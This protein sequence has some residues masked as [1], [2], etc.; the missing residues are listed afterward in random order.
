MTPDPPRHR[1]PT[2]AV[3]LL[4]LD[5]CG[6]SFG[7]RAAEPSPPRAFEKAILEAVSAD[8]AA[9]TVRDLVALGPR[10]GGTPSG[11]RA[12][13]YMRRR[14]QA[15]GL[16]VEELVD[17]PMD[18]HEEI[19]WEARLEEPEAPLH[20]WPVGFSPS[21]RSSRL[22]LLTAPPGP[23]GAGAWALLTGKDP[24]E[25][26]PQAV[27][28]G[29]VAILSDDD[30]EETLDP[31][32]AP[33]REFSGAGAGLLPAFCLSASSGRAVRALLEEGRP[34]MVRLGLV[35]RISR[36][37]PRT[38]EAT[39]PGKRRGWYLVVAHGD[40]DSGG[41]GAD[42]NASGVSSLLEVASALA[43]AS[44]SG[45][46]PVER[47]SIRFVVPGREIVSTRAY[48]AHRAGEIADLMGVFNFDQTGTS[49]GMD[50]L[51]FEGNDVPWNGPILRALLSVAS[52]YA[53]RFGF[54][55]AYTTNPTLGGTDACVFLPRAHHGLGF[56]PKEIPATTIFTAAWGRAQTTPQTP[57]WQSPAWPEK[58]VV[59][60]DY[61]RYYHS[62]AD[63]PE[64]TT[65]RHP[66]TMA[67][68][69]RAVALA[70]GR[71]MDPEADRGGVAPR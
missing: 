6:I 34:V 14:L 33:A 46:L 17:P 8:G 2:L 1:G 39:L 54:P 43:T 60:I 15:M 13:D 69:A 48:V 12:A 71:L 10:M 63:R 61:S 58:G 45:A 47:P 65:D 16:R 23:G 44:A 42:D 7:L 57:G 25:A 41:P 56:V 19:S 24:E 4:A 70:L 30:A 11:D 27:K 49:T 28:A 50:A 32:A 51:Y 9:H 31:D 37:R 21:L 35:S 3:L 5:P 36:G 67:R 29:A 64:Q 66:E 26:M 52:D 40:S 59:T 22:R 38:I 55:A 68:S 20:A 62:S 53:G 18:V